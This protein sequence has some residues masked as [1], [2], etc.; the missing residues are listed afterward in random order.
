MSA[1]AAPPP[2]TPGPV[3]LLRQ[4][5]IWMGFL[6]MW[7]VTTVLWSLAYV[8][9]RHE[10][11]AERPVLEGIYTG[12]LDGAS[13]AAACLAAFLAA[14]LIPL[15]PRR[16]L[17]GVLL[18]LAAVVA[19]V[20]ARQYAVQ[21]LFRLRNPDAWGFLESLSVLG[22]QHFMA[23]SLY[24]AAGHGVRSILVDRERRLALARLEARVAQ[25][26]FRALK[27]QLR[28]RFLFDHLAAVSALA[29]S[30]PSAAERL[31]AQVGEVLRLSLRHADRDRVPLQ[32]ELGLAMLFLETQRTRG[33][34][35]V[36]FR[37]TAQA[38][39]RDFPVPHLSVFPLVESAALCGAAEVEVAARCSAGWLELEVRDRGPLPLERRRAHPGWEPLALLG[40]RLEGL[41]G[42]HRLEVGAGADGGV[43][44]RLEIPLAPGEGS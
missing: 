27:T 13:W 5:G 15:H 18:T 26:R 16:A 1:A 35:P 44:A 17:R 28:P 9:I 36:R 42:G 31:L 8:L 24:L 33:G 12:V 7:G 43:V 3:T 6:A 14:W 38:L 10:V 19:I 39:E 4:R 23:V 22:A 11:R 41:G 25:E 37:A 34:A 29:G 40:A 2:G 30:D 32:Q 20:A 21:E